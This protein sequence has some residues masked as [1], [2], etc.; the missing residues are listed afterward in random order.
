MHSLKLPWP[1]RN[2]I[3]LPVDGAEEAFPVRRIYCV[4][5]N[6]AAHAKE[7]GSDEREPPFFFTKFPD[8]A[9]Q[10]G[11]A[12][13]YPSRSEN[14]HYEGELVI[15]IGESASAISSEEALTC[16]YGYAA[17]LDMTRRDLQLEARDKGRPWDTGKNFSQS[18]VVGSICRSAHFGN[19]FE[20]KTL[21]LSVNGQT[22]QQTDLGLMIWSCAEIISELST[23]DVLEPGDLIFTG[24]PEGVGA[25][26][27]GDRIELVINGLQPCVI[28]VE[29]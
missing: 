3:A 7:M 26:N 2:P 9:V 25:V 17:G 4:G 29:A 1:V 22:K 8:T 10:S 11:G 27:R 19:E 13:P 15:A 23:Y 18:A 12:I 24:T 6:Y 21:R 20:G 5:R 14:F 16:V 28:G